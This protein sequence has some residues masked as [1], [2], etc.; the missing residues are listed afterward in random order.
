MAPPSCP[1]APQGAAL[2]LSPALPRPW[3]GVRET[4]EAVIDGSIKG[5]I[6]LHLFSGPA[7]RA[8]GI[9]AFFRVEGWTCVDVDFINA[10]QEDL[11]NDALWELLFA[12]VRTDR[13]LFVWMGPPCTTFS[14]ARRH[15]SGPKP[16]RDAEHW[17]GFPKQWLSP[18]E[19]EEVRA[20][21]YFVIQCA[22]M[23]TL[24]LD[25]GKGF[26]IE[27]PKPWRSPECASMFDFEEIVE[28]SR[29]PGVG[30]TDLH[31][32]MYGAESAK[33]TRV[34]FGGMD[35][36]SLRTVCNH[37]FKYWWCDYKDNDNKRVQE[38]QW[39][40]HPKLVRTRL[41]DGSWATKAAAAY[42][43]PFNAAIV[44]SVCLKVREASVRTDG[45]QAS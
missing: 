7:E 5:P 9:A 10:P 26:A 11:L 20:A 15:G 6:A 29:R 22:R 40:R 28:L 32:C 24:L 37:P 41:D 36:S 30:S 19:V 2:P 4:L 34:L 39:A 42:P 35:L 38:W 13:V 27:N 16:V 31:Q 23:A 33:P 43:G 8:D 21:N 12:A 44:T 14:P 3:K 18:S 1:S 45:A 25:L 17:R